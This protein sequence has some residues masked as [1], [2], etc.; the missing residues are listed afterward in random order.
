MIQIYLGDCKSVGWRVS[1][2]WEENLTSWMMT[3]GQGTIAGR[4]RPHDTSILSISIYSRVIMN[5]K[6]NLKKY[7]SLELELKALHTKVRQDSDHESKKSI[8]TRGVLMTCIISFQTSSHL[9][10]ILIFAFWDIPMD[11]GPIKEEKTH[12]LSSKYLSIS[13]TSSMKLS[14]QKLFINKMITI[15]FT[16]SLMIL[17]LILS[18]SRALPSV[19]FIILNMFL[20]F[21]WKWLTLPSSYLVSSTSS[22]F[23]ISTTLVWIHLMNTHFNREPPS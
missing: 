14:I 3:G 21:M 1:R 18:T 22:P 13:L 5:F 15:S 16:S 12:H 17:I 6:L 10:S 11:W 9:S 4:K 8:H 20:D 23:K 2:I 19:I 7:L